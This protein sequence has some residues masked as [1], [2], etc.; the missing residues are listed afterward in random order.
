MARWIRRLGGELPGAPRLIVAP[1]AGAGA[2]SYRPFGQALAGR[3]EVWAL[4]P[5]G[6][7][8]R[9]GEPALREWAPWLD[10][11]AAALSEVGAERPWVLWGHSLGALAGAHLAARL[12]GGVAAPTHFVASGARP[13]FAVRWDDPDQLDDAAL[14]ARLRD[15]DGTPAEVL[16]S[17]E[18]MALL[19]PTLRADFKLAATYNAPAV[20]AW[21]GPLTV[22]ASLDDSAAP[23]AE[24]A[25]WAPVAQGPFTL[26]LFPGGHFFPFDGPRG[27]STAVLAALERV[28]GLPHG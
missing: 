12:A 24:A 15:L 25:G 11:A 28:L 21:P 10:G 27:V 13:P 1:H 22:F 5:P 26:A 9:L 20:G 18:L 17:D 6:R 8:A 19:L 3:A 23:H 4:T 14:L 7:E 16:A 2:L